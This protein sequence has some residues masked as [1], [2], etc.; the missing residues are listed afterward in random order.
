MA[1]HKNASTTC[2]APII[3]PA[4]AKSFTSPAPVAP[5]TWPGSISRQPSAN[6]SSDDATV[7]PLAPV[8]A[9][10]TPAAAVANEIAFGIRRWMTS[11]TEAVPAPTITAES[12][13]ASPLAITTASQLHRGD[14]APQNVRDRVADHRQQAH[15]GQR[16][17]GGQNPV[18]QQVL[19][20]IPS[21]QPTQARGRH[22][23]YSSPHLGALLDEPPHFTYPVRHGRKEALAE[24]NLPRPPCAGPPPS[25]TTRVYVVG[26]L[27]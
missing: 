20:I 13:N 10:V 23:R 7:T 5:S 3:A 4:A 22:D 15:H 17:Q 25:R 6:P 8:A 1:T 26:I 27:A 18:F 11:T 21:R 9:S 24:S 16:D 12:T 14:R 2:P 19:T